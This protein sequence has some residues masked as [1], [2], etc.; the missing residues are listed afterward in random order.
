MQNKKG[1]LLV[2]T[3]LLAASL[4]FVCLTACQGG[5]GGSGGQG[6]TGGQDNPGGSGGQVG[7]GWGTGAVVITKNEAG[8]ITTSF[9]VSETVYIQLI[10][11]TGQ[12]KITIIYYATEGSTGQPVETYEGV[13]NNGIV[14]FVPTLPGLYFVAVNDAD[15]QGCFVASST[16]F[17]VPET[18]LGSLMA[19][20]AGLAVFGLFKIKKWSK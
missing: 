4:I 2:F 1:I 11:V 15:D 19:L 8:E 6:G 20:S 5:N 10:G 9:S 3:V 17:V 18:A 13:T 16:F 14:E 12:N 7:Q